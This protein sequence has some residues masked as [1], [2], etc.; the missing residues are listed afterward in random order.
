MEE[1]KQ[2]YG[3]VRELKHENVKCGCD[4]QTIEDHSNV[5]KLCLI[6]M[7]YSNLHK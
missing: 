7:Q 3:K 4:A 1:L 2:C 5:D 6:T